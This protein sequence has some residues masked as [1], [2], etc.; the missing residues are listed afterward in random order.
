MGKGTK[1]SDTKPETKNA[2]T[3]SGSGHTQSERPQ[4]HHSKFLFFGRDRVEPIHVKLPS[5]DQNKETYFD[6]KKLPISSANSSREGSSSKKHEP[7]GPKPTLWQRILL[8]WADDES[9]LR[10]S[11][12]IV[13]IIL[14]SFICGGIVYAIENGE[15]ITTFWM[16]LYFVNTIYTTIGKDYCNLPGV[17]L[18]CITCNFRL[19][20]PC[21]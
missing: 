5:Y 3:E 19:R 17:K 2:W 14:F 13:V 15:Q 4:V 21:S 20:Y 11:W 6:E 8:A 7:K 10:L 1:S 16:A 9:N 12:P 18:V